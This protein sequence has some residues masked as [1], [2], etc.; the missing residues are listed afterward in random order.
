VN[1]KVEQIPL[2]QIRPN[3]WNRKHGGFN[4]AKLQELADSVKAVGVL[5]PA[6]VRFN[7]VSPHANEPNELVAGERRWRAAKLAG[8]ATLPC[9]VREID[10][11]TVMKIQTIE[12]LQ[13][14]DIHPLDEAEGYARLIAKGDYDVELLAKEVGRSPS[15][16][17]QRLKLQ[18][19]VEPGR[20]MLDAGK[21]QAGHA[22]LIARL[23]PAQQKE[24]LGSY[25]FR[26]GEEIS[27]RDI[28]SHI[29]Q[30]IL[31]DL[32]RASFKRDDAE[33][34]PKAG[35]CATC[36][37]RTG[38]QPALFADVCNGGKKDYCTDPPC[39]HG[40][41]EAL[42]QRRRQELKGGKHLEV[43]DRGAYGLDYREQQKLKK[44]GV[45]ESSA[46]EECKKGDEGAVPAL[47]VAG[48]NP[49]RLTYG[50][51][52]EQNRYG[53]SE[54]TAAEKKA[55]EKQLPEAKIKAATR[56]RIWDAVIGAFEAK[57]EAEAVHLEL[58]RLIALTFWNR[59]WENTR[60]LYCK[61]MGWEKPAKKAGEYG[62]P[63][64]RMGTGRLVNMSGGELFRFML[65]VCLVP[66]LE[67]PGWRETECKR[68]KK[69]AALYKL[70]TKALEAEVRQG[71]AEKAK[72]KEERAKKA[73]K[74]KAKKK[75][76]AKKPE[77]SK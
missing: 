51:E 58:S 11:I 19:L 8:L 76:P 21:I 36:P 43:M 40:K 16:V 23:Q 27:V 3:Q 57:P 1:E 48:D 44:I 53:R 17:Y 69:V 28:D 6:L 38:Y 30:R 47:V 63:W 37:K 50:R 77:T 74:P 45:K 7:P 2:E 34:D 62:N 13:R 4:K 22:I 26:R 61:T 46:W 33:L 18:D 64:E 59:T 35:P 60:A 56:R 66:D 14:E 5:H 25:L 49:G 73:A 54:L 42:V 72:A 20:K 32:S 68:L 67:G 39:F 52:R 9:V 12:N 71:F 29:R 75:T 41:L 55:R 10:D 31:L 15:Y 65:T 24:I 70:D